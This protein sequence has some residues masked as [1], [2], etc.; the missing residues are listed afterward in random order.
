MWLIKA[1]TSQ[2]APSSISGSGS[3]EELKK[4]FEAAIKIYE[5]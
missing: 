3:R 2:E 1:H 4:E 5:W